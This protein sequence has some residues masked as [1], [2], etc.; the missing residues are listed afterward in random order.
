MRQWM[1][2]PR[3]MC[4]QH[5]LGEHVEHHMFVGTINKEI[6]VSGY[7][8][9]NLLEPLSLYTRHNELVE[10]MKIRGY[11]HKSPLPSV[12]DGIL[13]VEQLAVKID[14]PAS[15][16]ELLRRCP[17]CRKRYNELNSNGRYTGR[18]V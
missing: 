1:C 4:R 2:D 9:D 14:R 11:N 18:D 13:T 6:G 5:L 16:A 10:E 8:A 3:I 17:E 12:V 15:L 7:L